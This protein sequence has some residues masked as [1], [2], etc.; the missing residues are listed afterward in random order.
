MRILLIVDDYVPN[1]I[2]I[3][4]KMMHEL[5]CE[6]INK[7]H[8]V[9]VITPDST[10]V[11]NIDLLQMDG[12]DIYRFKSGKIKNISKVKRAINETLLSFYGWRYC[13]DFL[14]NNPH[15]LIVYYSPSIFFAPLVYKLKKIWNVSSYLILRD[16]FPQWAIDNKL[17]GKYSL[18]T[19]YFKFFE[20]LNY[21][22]ADT[23]GLMS[24]KNIEW[25]KDYY[26]TN[27]PLE[28]LYNWADIKKVTNKNSKY[29]Q[30]LN[31]E[32]KIIF[33]YGGNMGY[34][35]DMMN[36]VRLAKNM[37]NETKAYFVL[38]GVGDEV[39]LIQDA[40]E[41]ES[42]TNIVLLPSVSQEEY[43]QMLYE[44]DIGLFTLNKNHNTHNFPGKLLGYMMQDMPILGS[45]NPN[46]DLKDLI[47]KFNAGLISV[48]GED[49]IFYENAK[50]LL[51]KNIRESIGKNAKILLISKFSVE[52]AA[53]QILKIN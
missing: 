6:F 5:A 47:D 30:N 19:Y 18:I 46:N 42:M 52:V 16:I 34:A 28:V 1:S 31:L 26:K 17:L 24:Q 53:K 43:E 40:I 8:Q 45:I 11:D 14:K 3:A 20:R 32:H 29:R 10:I 12:V 22:T 27:K 15:D 41:K 49:K 23:I 44:F 51:N 50:K 13:K 2:K 36:I 4:A 7:G 33:F 48:N 39:R 9:S 37:E 21:F 35:Q 38:V 25:F